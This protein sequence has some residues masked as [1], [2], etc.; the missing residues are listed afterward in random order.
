MVVMICD[1]PIDLRYP[2]GGHGINLNIED[3]DLRVLELA[4]FSATQFIRVI[5]YRSC[6]GASKPLTVPS[7]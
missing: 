4:S 3:I 6:E 5:I 7:Q 2:L 1:V